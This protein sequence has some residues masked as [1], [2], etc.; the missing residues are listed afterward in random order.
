MRLRGKGQLG[1][2]TAAAVTAR[3]SNEVARGAEFA[4]AT[5]ASG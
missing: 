5:T 2:R 4:S 1:E 3:R